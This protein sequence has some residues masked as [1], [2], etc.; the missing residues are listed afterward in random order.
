MRFIRCLLILFFA[1]SDVLN[2]QIT[3]GDTSRPAIALVF[4]GDEF[5]DGGAFIASALT[6]HQVKASFFLT[7]NFY[8]NPA[9]TRTIQQLK[10]DGHYLGSHSDKHLLYCDWANRDSL[11]ITRDSFFTDLDNAYRELKRWDISKVD[12]RYFL[13]PFEWYNDTIVEWTRQ[14]GLELINFTP[15]TRSTADYT[16]PEMGSRYVASDAILQ[17]ILHFEQ[18]SLSG[19][20]GCILLVHIGTDPRRKDKFYYLLPA[21]ISRLREKGYQFVRI[22]HLLD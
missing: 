12:A 13:P 10:N 21:L 17:S 20:N 2:A 4:T 3:R 5:N 19:L 8:R 9:F 7:G 22:D 18:H 11:L 16:Y 6:K 14:A 15:G 1:Q